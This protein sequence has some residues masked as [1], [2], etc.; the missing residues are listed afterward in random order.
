[1]H[2]EETAFFFIS[3]FF[4]SRIPIALVF[5]I[6]EQIRFWVQE[7]EQRTLIEMGKRGFK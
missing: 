6:D 2:N 4:F 1:M 5:G 7:T 3:L